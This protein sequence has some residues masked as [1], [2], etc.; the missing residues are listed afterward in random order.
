LKVHQIIEQREVFKFQLKSE[1]IYIDPPWNYLGGDNPSRGPR[2]FYNTMTDNDIFKL[3]ERMTDV[4]LLDICL[5]NFNLHQV[6]R[7]LEQLELEI[8]FNIDY[9]KLTSK[10]NLCL[11]LGFFLKHAKETLLL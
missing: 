1:I 4:E 5:V 3:I 8:F 7:K 11:T 10:D 6:L 9:I 2:I